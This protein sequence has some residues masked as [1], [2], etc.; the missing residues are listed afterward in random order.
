MNF[1]LRVSLA[2]LFILNALFACNEPNCTGKIA[3]ERN[4]LFIQAD[5]LQ[6][7]FVKYL[8]QCQENDA[9]S[10]SWQ[11]S[12]T[13]LSLA[14]IRS[15]IKNYSHLLDQQ[16][17]SDCKMCEKSE[18]ERLEKSLYDSL[19]TPEAQEIVQRVKEALADL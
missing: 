3:Q 16:N 2:L 10:R 15:D 1:R 7:R 8:K 9:H 17:A 19:Q 12:M 13:T 5:R 4:P 14:M 11:F 6:Q 18:A